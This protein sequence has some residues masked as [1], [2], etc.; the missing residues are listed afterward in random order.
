[1][2]PDPHRNRRRN[3]R[4]VDSGIG[5]K[6]TKDAI[7]EELIEEGFDWLERGGFRRFL[8]VLKVVLVAILIGAVLIGWQAFK[9][10]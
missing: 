1:M 8:F 10:A 2:M 4:I 9:P 3:K 7:T 6:S 5:N